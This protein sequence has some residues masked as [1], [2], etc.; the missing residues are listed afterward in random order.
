[1]IFVIYFRHELEEPSDNERAE[2]L[3]E[4]QEAIQRSLDACLPAII[5]PEEPR[6]I[7]DSS[8]ADPLHFTKLTSLRRSHQRKQAETGIRKQRPLAVENIESQVATDSEGT[9]GPGP[10]GAAVQK[11]MESETKQSRK[12]L[13]REFNAVIKAEE[14]RGIATAMGRKL[15]W[16]QGS[17]G[18]PGRKPIPPT[19]STITGNSANAQEVAASDTKK[20]CSGSHTMIFMLNL[21]HC[22]H[23][24][25]YCQNG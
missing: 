2:R 13:L 25:R 10:R 14:D 22:R 9:H 5:A 16:E 17:H 6:T 23:G 11:A 15:R 21:T 12:A 4:D 7:L 18:Q 19:A 8:E 1:L 3:K 24:L 20:V